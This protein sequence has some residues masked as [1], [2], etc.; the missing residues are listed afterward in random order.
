MLSGRVNTNL[1]A[2]VNLEL[3]GRHGKFQT[4]EFVLD[5][6]FDGDLSLP[7]DRIQELDLELLDLYEGVLANEQT[8][9]YLG[10]DGLVEWHGRRR[11]V[12]VLESPGDPLLGMNLL[13]RN[14]ITMD[15]HANGPIT[16]EE[17]N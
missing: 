2:R 7:A 1:E 15:V 3:I 14:R 8:A 9:F 4:V 13:W 11:S 6:G 17:L 5:T 10:Y 16:I 12:V